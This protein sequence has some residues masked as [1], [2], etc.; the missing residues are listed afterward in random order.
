MIIFSDHNG[1]LTTREF[2]FNLEYINGEL[3]KI[4]NNTPC[5]ILLHQA[6]AE[7]KFNVTIFKKLAAIDAIE[8]LQNLVIGKPSFYIAIIANKLNEY[9]KISDN[10][11]FIY[12]DTKKIIPKILP[13]HKSN[14]E[15]DIKK[16]NIVEIFNGPKLVRNNE[17]R[18]YIYKKPSEL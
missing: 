14:D 5:L 4:D 3:F 8:L 9:L 7:F 6:T 18:N 12:N 10:Y 15:S 1:I 16:E 17:K 13:P 2:E 11:N